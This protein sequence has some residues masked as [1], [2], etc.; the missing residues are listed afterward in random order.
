[1]TIDSLSGHSFSESRASRNVSLYTSSFLSANPKYYNISIDITHWQL[2]DLICKDTVTSSG[3]LYPSNNSIMSLNI[4]DN[5]RL[6][7]N[8][9]SKSSVIDRFD[10]KKYKST[11]SMFM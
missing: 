8:S 10:T 3:I 2:K 6:N 9:N 7:S 4:K 1:M 11:K 5:Y